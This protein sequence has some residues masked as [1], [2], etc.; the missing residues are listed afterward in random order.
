MF[1]PHTCSTTYAPRRVAHRPPTSKATAYLGRGGPNR[2]RL[3]PSVR[4]RR[5]VR[6][7]VGTRAP[8]PSASTGHWGRGLRATWSPLRNRWSMLSVADGHEPL[9]RQPERL[10]LLGEA[11][12]HAP[13]PLGGFGVERRAR[14]DREAVVDDQAAGKGHVVL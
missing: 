13:P 7:E 4:A 9:G 11:E 5:R 8:R 6:C 3:G 2:S 14:D 10:Q 1:G 12:A